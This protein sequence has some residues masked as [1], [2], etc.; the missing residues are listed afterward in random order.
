MMRGMPGRQLLRRASIAGYAVGVAGALA[1][2]TLSLF[3]TLG[4]PWGT[5]NDLALIATVVAL[6]VLMLAFWELGG[7]T[8]APLALAAQVTGWL[9][10]AT[11][12]VTHLLFIIGAVEIDYTAGAASGAL[13]IESVALVLLGLW[14]A[15]ANVLAGPWLS[16]MRWYGLIVGLG[17]VL[18]GLA[19]LAAG[20]N[21]PLI[22]AGALGYLVLFPVWGFLMG[23]YLAARVDAGR[24]GTQRQG[25]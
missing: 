6:P 22:Y 2:L 4:Q 25:A 24:A 9:A 1:L 5:I 13:A 18:Y 19:T 3:F 14:I 10:A 23:V 17:V 12:C 21:G 8:P 7:R 11:W 16:G 20:T 15:G